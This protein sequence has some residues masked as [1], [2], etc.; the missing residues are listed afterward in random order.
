MPRETGQRGVRAGWQV[1][2][3]WGMS[4]SPEGHAAI[5][6]GLKR[7][8]KWADRMPMSRGECQ[9][10]QL[11]RNNG[12]AEYRLWLSVWKAALWRK[13]QGSWWT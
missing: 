4:D 3:K 5:C 13:A 12:R 1:V 11:E 2:Q 6:R 10:L 9:V 8:E 7:L